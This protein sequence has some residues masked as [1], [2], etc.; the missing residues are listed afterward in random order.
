MR[1]RPSAAAGA[2]LVIRRRAGGGL[3]RGLVALDTLGIEML[4]HSNDET[5]G[6]LELVKVSSRHA[7]L[8]DVTRDSGV[9]NQVLAMLHMIVEQ[10][11]G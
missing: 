8:Q 11:Q 5:E 1:G 7:A 9:D 2:D 4:T 10:R 6:L 3:R